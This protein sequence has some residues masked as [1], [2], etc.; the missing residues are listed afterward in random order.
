MLFFP[1]FQPEGD[2]IIQQVTQIASLDNTTMMAADGLLNSNYMA[3]E[4]TEGMYFSGPDIRYGVN[5]NQSTG[6]TAD[7]FLAAYTDEWGEDPAAPFWA[8]SYDA[9]TLL[10]DAIAAAS[11]DNDGT[12][13][14]DRAGVREHLNGVTDYSG[15]I[16]LITCDAF[17][18]CGSQKITVIGHGDSTD[19][20]A[21]NAN[22]VYEYAPGGSSLG[23]GNLVVPAAKPQYGGTVIVGLEA[24]AV[25][26][27]P[28]EDACASSCYTMLGQLFDPLLRQAKSG[29]YLPW[30]A[31][32]IVPNDDFTVWTVTLR[33][34]VTFHNGKALT[35]QTYEDMFPIQQAG[36]AAAGA[37]ATTGLISVEATGD[38]TIDYTLSATNVAF[39]SFLEAAPI[40]YAF[41]P[42]AAADSTA[43]NA[44]PIGTG[45]FM[46][47]SRDIDNETIL[48]R[49]PN[50]WL[51][52]NGRQLP[53]LDSIA[54]RPIPDETTRLASLAS[55]TT[56]AMESRRQAT[57]RDARSLE[58]VTLY[59]F[60]GNDAGGGHFN[61]QV[62]PYDDVRVRRGLILAQNQEAVI[63]ALGGAGISSPVTQFFSVDSPWWSQAVADAYPNFDFDA[64]VA[65][66]QEYVDD[67]SRS[68]GKAAGEKIQVDLACPMDPTL[69]AATSVSGQLWTATGL[70][71]V[72]IDTAN[73]QQTHINVSLG[74][75]N[76]FLG[77]HGAHC[78]RY[79]SE[80]DPSVPIGQAYNNWQ[81]NP[82]NFSNY[83]NAEI[84]GY[85]AEALTTNVFE[86]R[87]ALYEKIGII[88]NRDMPHWFSGGTAT[89]IAVDEAITGVDTWLLPD[90]TLGI[91]H[92]SAIGMWS[93][94]SRTDN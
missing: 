52:I 57:V 18:D 93:Q 61:A 54:Y 85:L 76:G 28:W 4:E 50:Y 62:P 53:Y 20:S 37:I 27:R 5:T 29:A 15:I 41:D 75:G 63:E 10:L 74:I 36:A 91:G 55:G 58:G 9:T 26:L 83:D 38:L 8:H 13:V 47:D 25:G 22:V 19:V 70:V 17:G 33:S 31:E 77:E 45:A 42:E 35:G 12:L 71:D 56:S 87:Y 1:I 73:D 90:G 3:L 92:P 48:V 68:D 59:E 60:Q 11:Y 66:L 79:G 88:A 14:I 89:V 78:W 81:A 72:D 49:N 39:P 16:G 44:N 46:M 67:P 94:V 21:S 32:S 84:Q 2:F 7:S 69:V 30:L 82:L 86:E 24:E 23:E 34:G 65:L 64:G 43:F 51:S 80:A 6:Q 40:G